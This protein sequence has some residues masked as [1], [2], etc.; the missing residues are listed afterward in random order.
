MIPRRARQFQHSTPKLLERHSYTAEERS[1]H[2]RRSTCRLSII[3]TAASVRRLAMK[4]NLSALLSILL[5]HQSLTEDA[6]ILVFK[7]MYSGVSFGSIIILKVTILKYFP[8]TKNT[9]TSRI[10]LSINSV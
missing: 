1:Q 3:N 8:G 4:E 9:D 10:I 5:L 6:A 2:R 7:Y